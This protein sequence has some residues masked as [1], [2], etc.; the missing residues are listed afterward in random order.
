MQH[1]WISLAA[2]KLGGKNCPQIHGN[3]RFALRNESGSIFL[4]ETAYQAAASQAFHN[5]RIWDLL[6]VNFDAI[7]DLEDA[8]ERR[9]RRRAERQGA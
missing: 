8:D 2:D 1:N 9:A 3:G 5:S 6:P 4:Y 7:P